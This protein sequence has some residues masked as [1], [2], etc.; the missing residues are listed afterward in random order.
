MDQWET[1]TVRGT[2]RE[3]E[4]ELSR[5]LHE[6][7][8]GL[9]V[10]PLQLTLAQ[11]LER[12]LAD[13]ARANVSGKTFER[14]AEIVRLHLIPNLGGHRLRK[15]APLHIQAYYSDALSRGRINKTGGLSAQTVLHHH[16]VLR[17]A[18]QQAVSWQMLARN[19]ADAVEPPRPIRKEIR[20][21]DEDQT[22]RL[23]WSLEGSPLYV[24]VL[25][26]V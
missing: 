19:P 6:L 18:L 2:K 14:Y 25:V 26:A 23:L 5:V 17:E 1:A 21:L 8:T 22:A 13:C 24:P 15:L 4:A 12:W 7:D 9:Y 3:A 11:Y 20:V 16:R 10:D